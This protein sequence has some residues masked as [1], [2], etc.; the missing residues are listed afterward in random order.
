MKQDKRNLEQVGGFVTVHVALPPPL[1]KWAVKRAKD[2]GHKDLSAIL[3]RGID[4]LR[5]K[6]KAGL[7]LA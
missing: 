2:E 3:R 6:Q 4:C 7:P 5:E 1:M